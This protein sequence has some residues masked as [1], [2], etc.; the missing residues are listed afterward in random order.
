[1]ARPTTRGL[2]KRPQTTGGVVYLVLLLASLVSLAVVALGAWRTGIAA[3]GVSLL[4]AAGLRVV[5]PET[6]AGM[7]GVRRKASD[8]LGLVVVG[9]MLIVLSV[10]IPDQ[11]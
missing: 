2:L 3:L 9:V 4:V 6:E 1:M 7:L 8:V 11:T 10:L 5:L